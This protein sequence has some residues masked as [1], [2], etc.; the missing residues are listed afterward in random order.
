MT[1]LGE[2]QQ[3]GKEAMEAMPSFKPAIHSTEAHGALPSISLL[4][5]KIHVILK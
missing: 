1:A 3:H 4:L 2:Q 5:G